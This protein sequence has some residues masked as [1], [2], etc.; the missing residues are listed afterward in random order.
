[1]RADRLSDD[2]SVL[3][4]D[5]VEDLESYVR[6]HEPHGP[7]WVWD[8]SP[9][10]YA[11]LLAAGVRVARCTDLRLS[12]TILKTAAVTAHTDYARAPRDAWDETPTIE[13]EIVGALFELEQ[14]TAAPDPLAEFVAQR[15]AV[16]AAK[17][18]GRID[19]LLAAESVGALIAV[20]M[21][22][23]GLPWSAERHDEILT[24]LLGPR[25]P[26]GERP[27]ELARLAVQLRR[28]LDS[29]QL[30]PDS[31]ADVLRA[32]QVAGLKVESTRAWELM[33]I[34]HPVIEP[35]LEYKKLARL[36]TAN[37]WS[38]VDSW[39]ENGRFHPEYVPGGVVTGRWATSGGGALQLPKAI[40][41]AVRADAG[42]TFVVADAAQLEPRILGAMAGD[43][44]MIEAGLGVDLYSGIVSSGAVTTRDE[45]KIAMLSA[46]YGGTT[47]EG[48]RLM[49]RLARAY[50]KA[51][52]LVEEAAREG[53]RGG[54]VS[55]RLGRTSPRPG[56][57]WQRT[58]SEAYGENANP[59]LTNKARGEARAWGRFTRNFIVQGTAAEWAL[60]WMGG[61]RRRLHELSPKPL[62]EAPHLVFF[63]HDEIV[64]HTPLVHADA[65]AEIIRESAREAGR[66]LFGDL[67]AQ[68]PVTVAITDDYGQAK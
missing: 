4:T 3:A 25:P 40:R 48:G 61:V 68:F 49:P 19:R 53:E 66:L 14:P 58:Q 55:T 17:E 34:E 67:P 29:P 18:P 13:R 45:A 33:E 35:L 8:S 26:E 64:V 65:V 24:E 41:S 56:A 50:P 31:P 39:V 52:A 7:R 32:L 51:I 46:M 59:K 5:R 10:W 21:R 60:C 44:S 2:M 43:R 37:G 38:W 28:L 9:R 1:M 20:E 27:Q 11:P 16:A 63:L 62:L 47:G 23:A 22:F 54:T 36:L 42:W 57:A 12:R 30:N 6:E 15:A